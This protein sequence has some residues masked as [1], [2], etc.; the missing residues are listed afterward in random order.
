[1]Y[2]QSVILSIDVVIYCGIVDVVIIIVGVVN[3]VV[4]V[5]LYV[6]IIV[7]GIAVAY[8][9]VIVPATVVWDVVV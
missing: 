7:V 9:Y 1:M 2:V 3:V 5:V 6:V 4:H 8:R